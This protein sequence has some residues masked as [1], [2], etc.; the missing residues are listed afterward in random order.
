MV[1]GQ[2][3]KKNI[4]TQDSLRKTKKQKMSLQTVHM[5]VYRNAIVNELK[6]TQKLPLA[7][8]EQFDG[9]IK[10][11]KNPMNSNFWYFFTKL[12]SKL[13][14]IHKETNEAMT[15]WEWHFQKLQHGLTLDENNPDFTKG[16]EEN[17]HTKKLPKND[18]VLSQDKSHDK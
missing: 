13:A 3:W 15:E 6:S 14:Q 1:F 17:N 16:S 4:N 8:V 5:L 7:D 11:N 9:M 18:A 2:Q 12:I 10:N